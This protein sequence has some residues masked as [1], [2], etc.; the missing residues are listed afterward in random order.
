MPTASPTFSFVASSSQEAQAALV[1]L[2]HLYGT[3]VPEEADVIVALGGDGFM[4]QILH[5]TM[6]SGKRVYGMNRGS[7]GFL[8]NDYR[9]GDLPERIEAAM[10]ND[11]FP[12]RM[13]TTNSDGTTSSALAM[14]RTR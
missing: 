12:L 1:E 5:Q 8:M 11:F 13:T 3:A 7:V 2:V 10:E 14:S 6:N 4:L 9:I